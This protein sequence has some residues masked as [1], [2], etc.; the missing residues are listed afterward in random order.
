MFDGQ[1]GRTRLWVNAETTDLRVDILSED[2][3]VVYTT[4][5]L[6]S[7]TGT[8]IAVD[9]PGL[10]DLSQY[11]G[12]PLRYRFRLA[13]G[14]LYSFWIGDANGRSGGFLGAGGPEANGQLRDVQ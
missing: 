6:V 14:K 7:G 4:S 12:A 10:S 5:S 3:S 2:G 13:N 11:A 9:F 1:G 8:R